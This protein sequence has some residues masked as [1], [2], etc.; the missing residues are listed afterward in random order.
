MGESRILPCKPRYKHVTLR[1]PAGCGARVFKCDGK[2]VIPTRFCPQRAGG[3]TKSQSPEHKILEFLAKSPWSPKQMSQLQLSAGELGEIIP[4]HFDAK[5]DINSC[6]LQHMLLFVAENRR[7][8]PWD[9]P[10]R[11]AHV[12]L[13]HRTPSAPLAPFFR[14]QSLSCSITACYSFY[15]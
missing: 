15:T 5:L 12:H 2:E 1:S 7:P 6:Y 3:W 14:L 9:A 10:V 11:H 13:L 8:R 4:R